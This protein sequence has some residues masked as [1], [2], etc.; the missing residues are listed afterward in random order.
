MIVIGFHTGGAYE[1]EAELLKASLKK[2]GIFYHIK[3]IPETKT[4]HQAVSY[5][6]LFI[7]QMREKFKGALVSVDV[8]AVFHAD[9]SEYFNSLK[10]DFGAHWFQGPSGGYDKTRNDD[11]M[12]SG[13]MFWGD[14]SGARKL[15]KAWREVNAIKQARGDYVGGGQANLRDLIEG[16][17]GK[18][19]NVTRLPGEYCFVFDKP[20]AYPKDCKP[21][22]EH[23]IA[24]RENKDES[25]G[26]I[27]QPRQE[28]ISELKGKFNVR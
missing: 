14:T 25:K 4:W 15:L 20:W 1:R 11:W 27:N 8:D 18:S 28:R 13:T 12:L 26:K 16:E 22:I 6:P 23:T 17:F 9:P 19:I 3:K 7:S 5:K 10:T 2:C 24:S 21:V